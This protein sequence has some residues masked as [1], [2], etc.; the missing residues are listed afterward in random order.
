M[1][2]KETNDYSLITDISESVKEYFEQGNTV[3]QKKENLQN[4]NA[5][6][7][8]TEREKVINKDEIIMGF[9][10]GGMAVTFTKNKFCISTNVGMFDGKYRVFKISDFINLKLFMN[11]ENKTIDVYFDEEQ[12]PFTAFKKGFLNGNVGI[13]RNCNN[14]VQKILDSALEK[15][16]QELDVSRNDLIS[17][18]DKDNNGIIDIIEN[19][20]LRVLL[21]EHQDKIKEIDVTYLQKFVKVS[22]WLEVKKG[23][24]QQIFD[25]VKNADRMTQSK[26]IDSLNSEIHVYE[27]ILFNTFNMLSALIDDDMLTFYEIENAFDDLNMFDSKLEKDISEKLS[28]I[29]DGLNA[30][31]NEMN[32]STNRIIESVQTLTYVTAKTNERLEGHLKSI[33]SSIKVGNLVSSINAYQNWRQKKLSDVKSQ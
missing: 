4:E 15:N 10:V 7:Y 14:E 24:I 9:A 19:N 16:K 31:V 25:S 22:S 3:L 2:D 28:N 13:F 32:Q 26:I 21:N 27:Q 29:G 8:I 23:N 33:N 30:F 12:E 20:D 17:E 1:S 11:K 6:F 5:Y 18:L